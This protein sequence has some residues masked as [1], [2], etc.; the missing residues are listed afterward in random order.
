MRDT[1]KWGQM[2]E[3]ARQQALGY[4]RALPATEP[5]PPF[6]VVVDVGYCLDLYS[7]F[8]GV[9]DNYVPFPDSQTHRLRLSDLDDEKVVARLR[10]LFTNPQELDPSRRA[11]RV[12]RQLAAQLAALS[13]QL[14]RA[15]NGS[16][17]VAQ[18]LMRCVFTMFAEDVGLI[19]KESFSGL[20]AAYA[21]TDELRQLLPDAM[22]S[23]WH[24]MDKGG[25]APELRAKLRR[26][27]GQLFHDALALPLT[28]DQLLLLREAAKA[29]WTEV[30]PTIFGTLL[31]RALD[32]QERHRLGAHYTPRRY[33]ERLVVPAVI[34]PLRREWAAAQAAS[35]RRLGEDNPK[36]ARTELMTFLR[37]LTSVRILD[38]ACGSGN[39][40]YVT[41]EHLKRLE[42]EVLAAINRY[43]HTG[44]LELAGGTTVSPRQLLGLELNPR[45][46]TIADVVL[47]IGY[48]QWHVRTNGLSELREPLLDEY[49][50]VENRDALL[51]ADA[52]GN[53]RIAEWPAADFIVGNP[54]F[55]GDK[56]MRRA[57][58]GEYVDT[59][60]KAYAGRVPESADL[61]L[62]WW[63]K[64]AELLASGQ[65]ERFGFITTNS[66]TQ[67]FNRRVVQEFLTDASRP[68]ALA[69][70]I[71]DHPWVDAADGAAVRVAFTVAGPGASPGS[72]LRVT[73]EAA[74]DD[75]AHDVTLVEQSGTINADLTVGADVVSARALQANSEISG[76]GVLLIGAGFI[77][78]P[79]QAA[80]LGLGRVAGL[81]Q[82]IRPYR[83]GKDLMS[84]PRGVLVIDL[85]GLT[86]DD[87]LTRFPAVYQRVLETV[88]PERDTNNRAS[89]RD[90]WWLFGET[91]PR[92]RRMI[93]GLPRFIS[94]PETARHRVFQFLDGGI[95]P[96]NKV[97]T[98]ASDDAFHLGV[99]SSR[100]HVAWSLAAGGRLGVGNDSVYNKTRCFEPFPFPAATEPQRAEIRK[101]AEQL[102]GHRK[103][104]Q[105]LYSALTLTDLYNVVE[106]LRA[107]LPLTAKEQVTHKNG[108][109][110]VVGEL[111]RQLDAAV[112]AAYAWPA[113]LADADLLT[114]LV[115]L[116]RQRA[117]EEA[118]GQVRYLRPAQQ[119][120]ALV[121]AGQLSMGKTLATVPLANS[122]G[123][124]WVWPM[125]LAQQMR[126][127]R[128]AVEGAGVPVTAAEVAS[129]F[130]G[131]VKAK[132]V[133]PL[134]ESLAELALVRGMVG[135]LAYSA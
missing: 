73:H 19:P 31:E 102:D 105:A 69:Y 65:V 36:E 57:L 41:L 46:A 109:A 48:L 27:N 37:R 90:N 112:A 99:L 18:F 54:P 66:I 93:K 92:L 106:K 77:V 47:K 34:E 131:K 119:A 126:A 24:T 75:D 81:E 35:A 25:F 39:F 72:L 96:D 28:A 2:M 64:A 43:G 13:A 71:P 133:Q 49:R 59:L 86:Q 4:V 67:T 82:H 78:T 62:Y 110:A 12:T 17:V 103:R 3:A 87:V 23:L 29:D 38:P 61:V 11:A 130:S 84:N 45:A 58:G 5:R 50:N 89:R 98:V 129:R 117:A 6:V 114:R 26:F 127:V 123:N 68:V 15:G 85:F 63:Y 14:E 40:L 42:G 20:L 1:P 132:Q 44:L 79:Q 88:K 76:L 51:T 113:D 94:T 55:V 124:G 83:N 104:Q 108:L 53:G 95:L 122:A 52:T 128:D 9:G 32:P 22:A 97:V 16:E 135:A 121:G 120:P 125:S 80:H 60:R 118:A 115:Q 91:N 111:H 70:A 21:A 100:I 8:A 33:V 134:L 101:L 10:L 30:E 56:A 107:G 116:N 7:N 74:A